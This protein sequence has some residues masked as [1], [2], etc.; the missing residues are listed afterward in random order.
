M[1]SAGLGDEHKTRDRYSRWQG[2]LTWGNWNL[3]ATYWYYP[4]CDWEEIDETTISYEEGPL[5][6]RYGRFLLPVGQ[7]TWDES[8]YSGFV[9]LPLNEFNAYGGWLRR[10]RTGIGA[11]ASFTFGNQSLQASLTSRDHEQDRLAASRLDRASLRYTWYDDGLTLGASAFADTGSLGTQEQMLILDA[12]YSVPNWIFR[13]EVLGY[14]SD[15]QKTTSFYLD[16]Y[17]R[18]AG[19][20]DVTFVSR[21]ERRQNE[22]SGG[23]EDLEQWIL[24]AKARL[25]WDVQFVVNYAGGPDLN[26]VHLGGGWSFSLMKTLRF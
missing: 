10:E 7:T 16:A 20:S 6:F 2:D 11:D 23:Q 15:S 5:R 22:T 8:W 13:G 17:Y 25:P 19:W 14:L 21:F 24:G 18:P 9:F 12:R 4:F 3:R 1:S 26:R